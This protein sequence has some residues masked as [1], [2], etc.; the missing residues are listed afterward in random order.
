MSEQTNGNGSGEH[1]RDRRGAY[2]FSAT[3]A[4]IL[5]FLTVVELFVAVYMESI[6]LLLLLASIK[7]FLVVYYYMHISRLW[8][9]EGEH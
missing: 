5:A 9:P 4:L 6:A 8:K 3:I 1:K 7:A 2:R